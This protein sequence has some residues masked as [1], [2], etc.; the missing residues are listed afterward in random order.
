VVATADVKATFV[1]PGFGGGANWNGAAIDPQTGVMYIPIR[2]RPSAVGLAKGD[3][4]RTNMAYVQTNNVTLAGPRGLPLLKPPYAEMVAVDMNKGEQLWRVPVGGA[5]ASVR[6]N[7]ALKGL[8]LD[9]D[10]M[11]E[12]DIRPG[13]LLT[14][15]LLFMGE[16]G[17]ISASRGGDAFKA[18]D[19]KTGKIVWQMAMPTLTTGAPMTYTHKGRQYIVVAVSAPGK[20]TEMIALTLDGQSENG[21]PPPGGVPVGPAP[22]S[23]AATVAAITA[24]PEELALGKTG[25]DRACAACHAANGSGGV[26]P[27]I[28]GRSD[29]ANIARVIA[30]GQG[31]MPALA[32]SLTPAD[33]DA[34]AKYVVKNW[35]PKPAPARAGR[36]PAR[37][38][39]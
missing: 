9:F 38:E 13:P 3:P 4:A 30:Q 36:G 1:Y 17:T 19:K 32:N 25:Y 20:P 11:G 14:K 31:E 21:A 15:D 8:N 27:M 6:D 18:Y 10:H 16:S 26:G 2:H 34:I 37:P 12:F 23:I 29:F 35:G 22:P 7:P 5:P 39:D 24:T 33:I 28:T